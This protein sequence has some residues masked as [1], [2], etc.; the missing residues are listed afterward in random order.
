MDIKTEV[1]QFI[2]KHFFVA[3]PASLSDEVS[4][5]ETGIIDSTGVLELIT[6]IEGRFGVG[7]EDHEMLPDNFDSIGRIA[8]FVAR[9]Q[10]ASQI[11]S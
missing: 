9:K 6:F 2:I 10:A 3:D 7:V 1:R 8:A 11:A 5:L 4:L